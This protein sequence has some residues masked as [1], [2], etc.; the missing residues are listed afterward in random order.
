MPTLTLRLWEDFLNWMDSQWPSNE[1]F[2]SNIFDCNFLSSNYFG[3]CL[4][5][6]WKKKHSPLIMMD[7]C[8]FMQWLH[9]SGTTTCQQSDDQMLNV[10]ICISFLKFF[11]GHKSNLLGHWYPYF[12]LLL[13]SVLGFEANVDSLAYKHASSPVHNRFPEIH[14]WCYTCWHPHGVF[15]NKFSHGSLSCESCN[16]IHRKYV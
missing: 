2:E 10:C 1:I 15:K 9:L 7:V 11:G 8:A 3:S 14:L 12:G 16:E 6:F 4:G 13:M 5:D